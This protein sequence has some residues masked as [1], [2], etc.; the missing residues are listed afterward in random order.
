MSVP[1]GQAALLGTL[2]GITEFLPVSSSGHLAL[3]ELLFDVEEGG[4]A[5]NV[6]LHAGTLLATLI[7]LRRRV[8]PAV[9]EGSRALVQMIADSSAT[10]VVGGG[11]AAACVKEFGVADKM[12]HVSTG[13][14]A[15][16]ELLAGLE[17][18]GIKAL[19]EAAA[20]G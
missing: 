14:G 17:L 4:L 6:M 3:A 12:T 13:G 20:R 19:E 7:M 11:D 18:P 2:Q 10:T 16:L 1:A 9:V 5:F 8:A 15:S